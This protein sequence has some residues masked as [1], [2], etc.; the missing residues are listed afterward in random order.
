[1]DNKRL[2]FY[3][4]DTPLLIFESRRPSMQQW[5][6]ADGV[7]AE[8]DDVEVRYYSITN[9]EIVEIDG[10]EVVPL[11]GAGSLLSM[12]AMNESEDRGA[13]I[14]VRIPSEVSSVTGRY[15][16]YITTE[17]DN[18]ERITQRRDFTIDEYG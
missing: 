18:D 17:F 13:Y 1:M 6:D 16:M 10:N 7:P 8:P 5:A 15:S 2:T 9:Q 14:Y 12:S 4:N 3:P 11:G